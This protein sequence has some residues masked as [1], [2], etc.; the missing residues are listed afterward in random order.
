MNL[1]S[2]TPSLME[3]SDCSSDLLS[4]S[5]TTSPWLVLCGLDKYLSK[6]A[7][8][9]MVFRSPEN[10]HGEK[11]QVGDFLAHTQV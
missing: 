5:R 7:E 8:P 1:P 11:Y 10:T 6:Y 4:V 2:P 9:Y 3:A